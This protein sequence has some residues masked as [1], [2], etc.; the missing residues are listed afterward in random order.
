MAAN[1]VVAYGILEL[2]SQKQVIVNECLTFC[3]HFSTK[4]GVEENFDR[5]VQLRAGV[6]E[7]GLGRGHGRWRIH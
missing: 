2:I 4:R 6:E 3:S 5:R 7:S 1:G